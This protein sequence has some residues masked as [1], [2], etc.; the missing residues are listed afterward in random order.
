MSTT[1]TISHATLSFVHSSKLGFA[2]T[3][4]LVFLSCPVHAQHT[5]WGEKQHIPATSAVSTSAAVPNEAAAGQSPFLKELETLNAQFHARFTTLMD[6]P[7]RRDK[8]TLAA[9]R[10]RAESK[11]EVT[12]LQAI[13]NAEAA[14]ESNKRLSSA[15]LKDKDLQKAYDTL[16]ETRSKQIAATVKNVAQRIKPGYEKLLKKAIAAG[17]YDDAKIIKSIIVAMESGGDAKKF[18][19]K[20][21]DGVGV[22]EFFPNGVVTMSWRPHSRWDIETGNVIGNAVVTETGWKLQ[23][24]DENTLIE[25][26][27]KRWRRIKTK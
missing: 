21:G 8:S 23:L 27:G 20:W 3:A 10:K 6:Y 4:A 18:V 9:L 11:T 1:T 5:L 19:G 24:E 26:S 2:F 15:D 16:R 12:A 22:V 14:V 25:K 17:K 13:I 7:N